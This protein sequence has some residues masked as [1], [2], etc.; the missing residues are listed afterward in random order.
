MIHKIMVKS[1]TPEYP[2]L[3]GY[4]I[5]NILLTIPMII[6]NLWNF[7]AALI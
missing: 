4:A 3:K 6:K 7:A 5:H 2:L 1:F